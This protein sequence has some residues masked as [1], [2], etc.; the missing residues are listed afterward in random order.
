MDRGRNI[1]SLGCRIC[2]TSYEKRINRLDE[3]IDIYGAWIDACV[4]ANTQ[5]AEQA[6]RKMASNEEDGRF[7]SSAVPSRG[8][9]SRVPSRVGRGEDRSGPASGDERDFRRRSPADEEDD[10]GDEGDESDED[11]R[12]TSEFVE[13]RASGGARLKRLRVGRGRDESSEDDSDEP[14]GNDAEASR[15]AMGV[16]KKLREQ[17][18]K[19]EDAESGRDEALFEDDE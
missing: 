11:A 5:A 19:E 1:G 15:D 3:P 2:G 17:Q 16:L 7:D 14:R 18:K 8:F 9:V 13:N 10:E 12:R 4:T 6:Q